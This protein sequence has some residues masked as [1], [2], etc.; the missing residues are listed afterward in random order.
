MLIELLTQ[1]HLQHTLFPSLERR[2]KQL[3]RSMFILFAVDLI[4]NT[5]TVITI[6]NGNLLACHCGIYDET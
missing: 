6:L 5:T 2:W 3:I 4:S 1:E